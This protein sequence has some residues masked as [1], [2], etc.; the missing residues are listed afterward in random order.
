MPV[1][2][3][4]ALFLTGTLTGAML[5]ALVMSAVPAAPQEADDTPPGEVEMG[6]QPEAQSDDDRIAEEPDAAPKAT[7]DRGPFAFFDPEGELRVAEGACGDE[8]AAWIN[9]TV[10]DLDGSWTL[11]IGPGRGEEPLAGAGR[12]AVMIDTEAANGAFTVGGATFAGDVP[13][14]IVRSGEIP[15]ASAE[16]VPDVTSELAAEVIGC[17]FDRLARVTARGALSA[18]NGAKPFLLALAVPNARTMIGVLQTGE[19]E[20]AS[21][22]LVRLLR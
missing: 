21:V 10:M 14:E 6:A 1:N 9:T 17:A 18:E 16:G 2:L 4:R 8:A 7:G 3:S 15:A 19:G 11:E 12:D 5:G 13:L 22:H 20:G